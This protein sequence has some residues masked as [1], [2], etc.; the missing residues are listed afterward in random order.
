MPKGKY[1]ESYP[2]ER[3][4]GRKRGTPNKRSAPQLEPAIAGG[5]M[6]LEHLLKVMRDPRKLPRPTV[7]SS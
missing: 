6:P 4:G 2:G 3:M 7:T 5:M 1:G